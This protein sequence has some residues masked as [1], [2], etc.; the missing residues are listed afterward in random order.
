MKTTKTRTLR[1]AGIEMAI[2]ESMTD[3]EVAAFCGIALQFRR[4]DHFY[5]NDY[6]KPFYYFEDYV[7]VS[8][9]TRD[10]LEGEDEARAARDAR[11]EEIIKAE[12]AKAEA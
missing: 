3:K 4:I 11:N 7:E 5:A 1:I 8:R 2:P 9:G 6:R 12:A 10:V